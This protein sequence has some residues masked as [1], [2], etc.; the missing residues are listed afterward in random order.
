VQGL[1]E[2]ARTRRRSVLHLLTL[3]LVLLAAGRTHADELAACREARHDRPGEA[4][5]LCTSALQNARGVDAA[6][7][8]RMH[9]AELTTASG[10]L[11]AA[12]QHLDAAER[13]LPRIADPLGRHRLARRLGL[14]AYRRNDFG[15]SLSRFLE[16]LAAARTVGDERALAISENDLG[17]VY[18]RLGDD[19]QAL[20]HWLASLESKR[21]QGDADLA[22]TENNIGNL[23]RDLREPVQAEAYLRRALAGHEAAQRVLLAAHTREDLG[24]LAGD[25]AEWAAARA[26]FDSA[27]AVYLH[28]R[29]WVDQLRLARHRAE[30]EWRAGDLDGARTWADRAEAL[31]QQLGLPAPADMA[32]VQANLLASAGQAGQALRYLDEREALLQ[33]AELALVQA[34]RDAQARWATSLGRFDVALAHLR[35]AHAAEVELMQRRHGERMDALRTRF[36]F[37]ELEHERDRLQRINAEQALTLQQRRN[38][39]LAL[40]LLSVLV[41]AILLVVYQR[42][43]F[44]QRLRLQQIEAEQRAQADEARHVAESLRADLRSVRVALDQTA[45][46]VLV[47]DAAG[48]IRLANAA[49]AER[50]ERSEHSLRG[51]TLADLFGGDAAAQLQNALERLSGG[52]PDA[53]VLVSSTG[54]SELRIRA[55]SL[56]LEEELG[57]LALE[58]NAAAPEWVEVLNRAHAQWEQADAGVVPEAGQAEDAEQGQEAR[59]AIVALMQA[60]VDAWE[61]STCSTRLELAEQSGIWRITI[62]DG[63]LRTRTLNRYLDLSTLPARPRWREVL[64]TAYFILAECKLDTTQRQRIEACIGELQERTRGSL[65]V[66]AGHR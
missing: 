43:L 53:P 51:Q 47:V 4:L 2:K 62:D 36:E 1:I 65:L 11:D 16:G 40:G 48:V 50:L 29:A 42:R 55:L 10:A 49:A 58:N 33:G 30:F 44:R 46:P 59:R 13:D 18:R 54:G 17:V 14:L 60:C 34:W 52:E 20:T 37:V 32:V 66:G 56:S 28:E 3:W 22:A 41:M 15:A 23:Y 39:L 6:F 57:V 61:R 35:A 7:E 25:R 24:L 5:A 9:L 12:Q 64:R 27:W 63:R 31:A 38:Q 26:E 19:R 45:G 8:A 21:R